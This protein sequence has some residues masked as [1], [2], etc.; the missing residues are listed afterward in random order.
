MTFGF[1]APNPPENIKIGAVFVFHQNWGYI[2]YIS[3]KFGAYT[4]IR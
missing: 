3:G 2:N 4:L 1:E